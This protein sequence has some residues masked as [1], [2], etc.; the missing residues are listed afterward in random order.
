[1][2]VFKEAAKEK[3]TVFAEN[4]FGMKLNAPEGPQDVAERHDGTVRGPR[5]LPQRS[6]KWL[7]DGERM[8]TDC[9]ELRRKPAK[10]FVAAIVFDLTNLT[11]YRFYTRHDTAKFQRNPLVTETDAENRDRGVANHLGGNA[12]IAQI[13]WMARAGG[14]D[15]G[16]EAISFDLL[17]CPFVVADHLRHVAGNTGSGVREVIGK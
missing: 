9:M 1:M 16:V 4:R 7:R 17:P 6:W 14:N 8:I 3:S 2:G 15:N 5:D 13:A 10:K 11:M 12:E